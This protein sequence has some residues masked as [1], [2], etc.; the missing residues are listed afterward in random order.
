MTVVEGETELLFPAPSVDP[1]D[2]LRG[3]EATARLALDGPNVLPSAR[4]PPAWWRLAA[5]MVHFFALMLWV[6]G[7]LALVAGLP[8]LGVAIFVVIVVNGLFAFVQEQ[9][10]ELEVEVHDGGQPHYPLLFGAE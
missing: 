8:Q 3:A 1:R 4:T 5:Q 9:H 10:P 6:A 7:L 2:G